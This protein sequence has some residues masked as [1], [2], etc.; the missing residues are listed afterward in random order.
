MTKLNP[1]IHAADA[2]PCWM[3][4]GP[5]CENAGFNTV[6]THKGATHEIKHIHVRSK[7]R[8]GDCGIEFASHHLVFMRVRNYVAN[9]VGVAGRPDGEW[10][11]LAQRELPELLSEGVA[12]EGSLLGGGL[13]TSPFPIGRI[14]PFIVTVSAVTS[15]PFS[16]TTNNLRPAT[17]IVLDA[18]YGA[19]SKWLVRTCSNRNRFVRGPVLMVLRISSGL[20]CAGCGFLCFQINQKVAQSGVSGVWYVSVD[21]FR[22]PRIR[23]IGAVGNL[24]PLALVLIQHF[25]NLG[26]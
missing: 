16:W 3:V 12:S 19:V 18:R 11:H 26:V 14:A 8:I 20:L 23:H 7:E 4:S 5:L 6:I 15:M 17:W 1:W 9:L 21:E 25:K 13:P 2:L 24:L 10:N 22:N